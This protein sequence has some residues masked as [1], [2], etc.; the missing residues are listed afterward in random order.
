MPKKNLVKFK[1]YDKD[2]PAPTEEG[3]NLMLR[4]RVDGVIFPGQLVFVPMNCILS[5]AKQ[6]FL[7]IL[8][9]ETIKKGGVLA[10]PLFTKNTDEELGVIIRATDPLWTLELNKITVAAVPLSR[11]AMEFKKEDA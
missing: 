3:G 10:S 5:D 4:P 8:D 2:M 11:V 9:V 1:V 7:A 6:L